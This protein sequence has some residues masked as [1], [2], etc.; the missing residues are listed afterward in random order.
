LTF[1]SSTYMVHYIYQ[2]IGAFSA[3]PT[4]SKL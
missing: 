2:K 1:Y 4:H 3:I